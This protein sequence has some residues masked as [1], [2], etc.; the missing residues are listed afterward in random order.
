MLATCNV[1][2]AA[3]AL[4]TLVPRAPPPP[5]LPPPRGCAL[6]LRLSPSRPP[7]APPATS[8]SERQLLMKPPARPNIEA[9]PR[10]SGERRRA[11][12]S[13]A[14]P[15]PL[16]LHRQAS[17]AAPALQALPPRP[18]P[19]PHP[20][21]PR[22]PVFN[23]LQD[24]LPKLQAAN[25]KL[26]QQLQVRRRRPPRARTR[27]ARA[28]VASAGCGARPAREGSVVASFTALM[29][30]PRPRRRAAAGSPPAARRG[31]GRV[32]ALAL[33]GAQRRPRP[34]LPPLCRPARR[35]RAT[36]TLKTWRR[37]PRRP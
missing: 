16:L 19:H 9:M 13:P 7:A 32:S 15:R 8:P 24:F 31:R 35:P 18:H 36:W 25:Q 20:P 26:E 6:P 14:H 29:A 28:L 11:A 34:A 12:L 1:K 17:A 21:H 33:S 3:R 10:S 27:H 4:W 30:P 23:R 22:P 5:L 2:L 37:A